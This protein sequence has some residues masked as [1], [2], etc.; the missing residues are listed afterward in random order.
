MRTEKMKA[1]KV[2]AGNYCAYQD[3]TQQEV[4]DK[5]YELG[6]YRDEVEDVL[7]ELIMEDFVN[8]ERY[9]TSFARGKFNLKRWGRIKI[10]Y[11]LKR[12][13]ISPYCIKQ[14]MLEIPDEEY[15]KTI[16][17]LIDKKKTSYS[18]T[19]YE[20]NSK[21]AKFL[22]NKGFE[23]ELVWEKLKTF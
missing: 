19:E 5:L 23:A 4:R 13:K 1:A 14:A 9:A 8:E 6:L 20:I 12:R 3:R 22:I 10:T 18:G 2:K 21:T 17:N 11:E 16:E 7:T 15:D